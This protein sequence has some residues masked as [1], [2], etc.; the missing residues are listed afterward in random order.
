[1]DD[2]SSVEYR[3]LSTAFSVP[4]DCFTIWSV[5]LMC[6]LVIGPH[7]ALS[8]VVAIPLNYM[9]ANIYCPHNATC[10]TV[11]P[12]YYYHWTKWL[13]IYTVHTMPH[14]ALSHVVPIPLNYM[15]ANIYCPHNAAH[16]TG[17]PC[18]YYHWTTWLL[19]YT[20]H[21]MP[22]IALS[23]VVPIPLNYMAANIYCPHN[24]TR[25]TV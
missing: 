22:H 4:H 11:S 20:V 7:V 18:Y 16:C 12:C 17:S 2:K 8:H 1:M 24:A 23:H 21:T 14:I 6:H 15:A 25:C 13:L 5:G 19:I 9:A 3:K 10:C